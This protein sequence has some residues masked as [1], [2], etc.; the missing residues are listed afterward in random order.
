MIL[1]VIIVILYIYPVNIPKA[2][3]QMKVQSNLHQGI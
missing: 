2:S 3:V 1:R